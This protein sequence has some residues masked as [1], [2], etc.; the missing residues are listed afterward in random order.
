LPG[1]IRTALPVAESLRDRVLSLPV[2]PG[3]SADQLEFLHESI[4]TVGKKPWWA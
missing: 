3:L 2:H 4:V 1:V